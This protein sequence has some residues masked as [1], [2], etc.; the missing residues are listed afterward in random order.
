MLI[1]VKTSEF[2]LFK[3]GYVYGFGIKENNIVVIAPTEIKENFCIDSKSFDMLKLLDGK[4]TVDKEFKIKS[5]KGNYKGKLIDSNFV[6]PKLDFD[7]SFKVQTKNLKIASKFV[8]NSMTRP[9][10]T[11][12]NVNDLGS[13]SATDGFK[14]FRNFKGNSTNYITISKEFIDLMQDNEIEIFFNDNS[15]MFEQNGI[16]YVSNLIIGM[17]PQTDK[18]F[19]CSGVVFEMNKKELLDNISLS[20]NVGYI[21]VGK[22]K[23][24]ITKFKENKMVSSGENDFEIE[25]DTHNIDLTFAL[26]NFELIIDNCNKVVFDYIDDK[27]P[28]KIIDDENEYLLMVM[29][30]A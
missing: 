9:V 22:D 8:A 30:N 27:R 29:I 7:K 25:L 24:I 20:K 3:D 12:V 14:C 5:K 1:N 17:Y 15:C 28:L 2:Q 10:L 16:K 26:D 13:I 21:K 18:I 6:V 19:N 11:G 4:I 23:K